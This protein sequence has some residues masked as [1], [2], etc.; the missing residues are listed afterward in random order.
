MVLGGLV[1]IAASSVMLIRFSVEHKQKEQQLFEQA[2]L[3]RR[4]EQS[5]A[6]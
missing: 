5:S 4:S 6:A 2:V 1:V 3:E